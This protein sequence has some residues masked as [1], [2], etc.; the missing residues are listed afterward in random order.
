[1]NRYMQIGFEVS[2]CYRYLVSGSE[3]RNA[4]IYDI[5]SGKVVEKAKG[6]ETVTD[7]SFN[8]VYNE[9]AMSSVDGH[10]RVFRNPAYKTKTP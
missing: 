9:W 4:Y 10:A 7:V 2:N 5:G 3:N 8:A 1:M 6:S